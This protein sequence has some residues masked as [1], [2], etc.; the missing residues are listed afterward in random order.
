MIKTLFRAFLIP[1]VAII[2]VLL[3][4]YFY[5]NWENPLIAA[6][7]VGAAVA[8]IWAVIYLEIIKPYFDRPRLII[9]EPGFKPSFYRQ[10][11][12]KNRDGQQV[13]IGYYI[14]ILLK[15]IGKR[16]AKNCQPILTAMWKL[17][18]GTWQKEE[19]WISV[20]LRWGAGEDQYYEH[21][22]LKQRE[23]RNLIPNRPYYLSLGRI[24]T[25]D[26]QIF[27]LLQV[28]ILNAQDHRFE[29][30]EYC[31][32]VAVNGEDID[33]PVKYF[34]VRWDGKCTGNLN[35]VNERFFV[36]MDDNPPSNSAQ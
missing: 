16:T 33:P 17:N 27:E 21:G 7:T 6:G 32:E 11:P 14:N 31:F 12:E 13:G 25:H 26:C 20:A 3:I 29:P 4:S 23:E 15:N 28:I 5:K 24:S 35:E 34:K 19:N 2:V 22:I 30:G 10:A 18:Q 1:V 9:K 8:A 36:S